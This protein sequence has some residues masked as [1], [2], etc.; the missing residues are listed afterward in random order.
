M[1]N[2]IFFYIFIVFVSI[3]LKYTYMLIHDVTPYR[4]MYG[5]VMRCVWRIKIM[6]SSFS[7][8]FFII[9]ISW[10]CELCQIQWK[11][12]R[13]WNTKKPKPHT[14]ECR[15]NVVQ[16]ITILHTVLRCQQKNMNQ[17]SKFSQ[18]TPHSSPSWASY[19]VPI[20]RMLKRIGW[21]DNGLKL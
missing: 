5:H 21:P 14:L 2:L 7:L 17:T 3:D 1:Q 8:C 11:P 13:D 16:F 9:H 10:R 15:C 20:V 18:Q 19:G 4:N 12:S 6:Y